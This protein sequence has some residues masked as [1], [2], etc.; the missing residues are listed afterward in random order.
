MEARFM[1]KDGSYAAWFRTPRGEG[2]G[3][4]HFADGKVWGRDSIVSYS[5]WYEVAGD[6]FSIVLTTKRHTEGHATVFGID[7]FELKLEGV[8]KGTIATCSGTADLAPDLAFDAILIPRQPE[9]SGSET[10]P[11]VR[12]NSGRLPRLKGRLRAS[13]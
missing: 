7:E 4:I 1:L 6:R 10:P 9:T 2:T 3:I 12:L 8:S 11:P 5:G 13:Y